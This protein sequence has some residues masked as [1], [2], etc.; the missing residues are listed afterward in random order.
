MKMKTGQLKPVAKKILLAALLAIIIIPL[1][2][3]PLIQIKPAIATDEILLDSYS[4]DNQDHNAALNGAYQS[5][6]RA[7][8]QTFTTPPKT[9]S[10]ISSAQFLL[11][12]A[13]GNPT[14]QIAVQIYAVSGIQGTNAI[15]KGNP[16][17]E[18][19]SVNI[20]SLTKT[21][22]LTAFTLSIDQQVT[23]MPS[24]NYAVVLVG[25]TGTLTFSDDNYVQ[26]GVDISSPTH[27]GNRVYYQNGTWK[28]SGLQDCV[29]YVYGYEPEASAFGF[30]GANWLDGWEHRQTLELNGVAADVRYSS[31]SFS[32]TVV[33]GTGFSP[34]QYNSLY[35]AAMTTLTSNI[36]NYQGYNT[37][38]PHAQAYPIP[39]CWDTYFSALSALNFNTTLAREIINAAFATQKANGMI[40]NAPSPACDMDMHSQMPLLANAVLEYYLATADTAS[41]KVWY[42]K[43]RAYYDWYETYGDPE[44]SL[45]MLISPFTSRRTP[46][47]NKT[48]FF[49]ASATGLDNFPVYD[50]TGGRTIRIGN[51]HYFGISDLLLS[52][53][54]ALFAQSMASIAEILGDSSAQ[55]I[56]ARKHA[57]LANLINQYMWDFNDGLYKPVFWNTTK[58]DINTV[59][60]FLPLIANI[61]SPTQASALLT[62]L[63]NNSE[64]NLQYGIPTVAANDPH[65]YSPQPPYFHSADPDYWRGNIW[66]PTTYLVYRGLNNYGYQKEAEEI[67]TKWLSTVNNEAYCPFAEYYNAKTGRAGNSLSNFSWTAAVTVLLLAELSKVSSQEPI[68]FVNNKTKDDFSDIRFFIGDTQLYYWAQTLDIGV[69]ATFWL[70]IPRHLTGKPVYVYF[71]NPKATWDSTYYSRLKAFSL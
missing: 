41:L 5:D 25:K 66:A 27:E 36:K 55:T 28:A 4:E 8:G 49:I 32:L 38:V 62:H 26:V 65:Y 19:N 14:G 9:Q 18:S 71:G 22:Q 11:R 42:P 10:R 46:A 34:K 20:S 63:M 53:G 21:Y 40:P 6:H 67:A 64:Y 61:P 69:N 2:L 50:F 15:P 45:Y 70:K 58:V 31:L 44:G 23:L 3:M 60:T 30:S 12:Q 16:L 7:V 24:T 59:Q 33:N 57:F 1:A 47:D 54:M 52:S 56:Y 29:F 68:I 43:L 51:Y 13:Q 39:Y 35:N 48:A 37:I 17:A